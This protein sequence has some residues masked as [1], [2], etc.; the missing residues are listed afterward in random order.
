MPPGRGGS[1]GDEAEQHHP[2]VGVGAEAIPPVGREGEFGEGQHP[3]R[4][5][6]F[7]ALRPE[8]GSEGLGRMVVVGGGERA[9]YDV[10]ETVRAQHPGEPAADRTVTAGR[11]LGAGHLG[12][13]ARHLRVGRFGD[14]PTGGVHLGDDH[15]AAGPQHPTDLGEHLRRVRHMLQDV[16]QQDGV[17]A[18]RLQRKVRRVGDDQLG[19]GALGMG[20][21]CFVD[22]DGDDREVG[23]R[24]AQAARDRAR[25]GPEFEQG[26]GLGDAQ[27]AQDAQLFGEGQGGLCFEAGQLAGQPAGGGPDRIVR[28][29]LEGR[30][31]HRVLTIMLMPCRGRRV[32]RASGSTGKSLTSSSST[33]CV[34]MAST[35]VASTIAKCW[36]MQIRSP[37]PKGM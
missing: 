36:P 4:Q 16:A 22:V 31:V 10:L 20:Q 23:K 3:G 2:G 37:P 18:A 19:A 9:Q 32:T 25:S 27:L 5:Q 28:T 24:G 6:G 17:D 8:M 21:Q 30:G 11:A 34:N 12:V 35:R 14:A 29:A 33:D 7:E 15:P 13:D 1:G 26:R